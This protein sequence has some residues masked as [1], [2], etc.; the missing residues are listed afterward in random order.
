MSVLL[1]IVGVLWIA[2]AL[3]GGLAMLGKG[4]PG[5][6]AAWIGFGVFSGLVLVAFGRLIDLASDLLDVV[7]APERSAMRQKRRS[8]PAAPPNHGVEPAQTWV[9][10]PWEKEAS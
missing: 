7:L 4:E 9:R 2:F 1:E 3:L 5:S 6:A 10:P 8:T